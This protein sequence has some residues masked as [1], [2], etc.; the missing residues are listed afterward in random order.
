MVEQI[1]ENQT[2]LLG[3]HPKD[4][5]EHPVAKRMTDQLVYI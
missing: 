2:K 5:I 1:D 4:C 3:H